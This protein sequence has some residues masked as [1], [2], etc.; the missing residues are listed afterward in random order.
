MKTEYSRMMGQI[1]LSGEKKVEIAALLTQPRR[2][3]FPAAK[4]VLAAALVLGGLLCVASGVPGRSPY[5][6]AN[7]GSFS[8]DAYGSRFACGDSSYCPVEIRDGRMWLIVDGQETD[9]TDL[10]DEETPYIYT[11]TDPISG[12]EGYMIVGGTP[13]DFGWAEFC[14]GDDFGAA[15][16][17]IN[18][19]DEMLEIDG[20]TILESELTE[21]QR[22]RVR[23]E[24]RGAQPGEDPFHGTTVERPWLAEA[25][26]RLGI[27]P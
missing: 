7:G 27:Y 22:E 2:R 26:D 19:S 3:R 4:L 9:I 15:G 14:V 1:M 17:A 12:I 24:R 11:R 8:I 16:T 18:G 10:V 23:T 21:E 25:K 6:F 13:E 20:Q 5:H